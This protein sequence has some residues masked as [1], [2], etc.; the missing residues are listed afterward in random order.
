MSCNPSKCTSHS[1][2]CVNRLS[3]DVWKEITVEDICNSPDA[4]FADIDKMVKYYQK[5]LE[6]RTEFWLR[7]LTDGQ[8]KDL[9][10]TNFICGEA[11]ISKYPA[12]KKFCKNSHQRRRSYD[13]IIE[14]RNKLESCDF[15]Q[16]DT[17]SGI[18]EKVISETKGIKWF[19]TLCCYDFAL[20]YAY[21]RNIFPEEIYI[22]AG[23]ASGLDRLKYIY[24]DI[25]EETH[26]IFGR[27]IKDISSL[28]APIASLKPFHI[29]NFLCIFH[30]HL[31]RYENYIRGIN[32]DV[33]PNY[34]NY[35]KTEKEKQSKRILKSV[36]MRRELDT[37]YSKAKEQFAKSHLTANKNNKPK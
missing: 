36:K 26:P 4:E 17:F 14:V 2:N 10:I 1:S 19:S 15:E 23:T 12:D 18:L 24:K 9:W 28:P 34:A 5:N 29:E 6:E 13:T 35:K 33:G 7:S 3:N 16:Y 32:G 8:N 20:R 22:H 11:N 30:D 27:I 21:H 37:I 25:K 31:L